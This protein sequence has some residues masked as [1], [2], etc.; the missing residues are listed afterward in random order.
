[1]CCARSGGGTIRLR[2]ELAHEANRGLGAAQAWLEP[3]H[4]QHPSVSYADLFTL[5][6]AVAIEAM[7]GPHIPWRSGRVDERDA[8]KVTPDGRLPEAD[9][10]KP[11]ATAAGL[12]KTFGRMGAHLHARMH[13]V[14]AGCG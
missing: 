9:K 7:G 14:L 12:R 4:A 5:A 8:A 6:G 11:E 10:G 3:V 2:E 13:A 1:M